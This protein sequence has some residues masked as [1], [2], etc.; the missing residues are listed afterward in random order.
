MCV[1]SIPFG[2]RYVQQTREAPATKIRRN[3]LEWGIRGH[4][5]RM[6]SL[7]LL[8]KVFF[9]LCEKCWYANEARERERK[10]NIKKVLNEPL[11]QN[12]SVGSQRNGESSAAKACFG[13]TCFGGQP[14]VKECNK[15][16]NRKGIYKN[17]QTASF[18]LHKAAGRERKSLK[19]KESDKHR[20]R[21]ELEGF[22]SLM[23][24]RR[25]WETSA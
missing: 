15:R 16:G 9:R 12:S 10:S 18:S 8:K 6:A 13:W 14:Q 21:I 22:F 5:R 4:K 19:M 23:R 2:S 24:V 25:G 3:M 20:K 11:Q 1:L 7:S 17:E